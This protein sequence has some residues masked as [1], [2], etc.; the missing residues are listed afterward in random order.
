MID[1]YSSAKE[2][3]IIV[4]PSALSEKQCLDIQ[5]IVLRDQIYNNNESIEFKDESLAQL[6]WEKIKDKVPST[7]SRDLDLVGIDSNFQICN[8]L[9]VCCESYTIIFEKDVYRLS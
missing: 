3:G 7:L 8:G 1:D 9:C 5:R 2:S 6:L 4:V